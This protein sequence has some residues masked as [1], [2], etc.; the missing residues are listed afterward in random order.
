MSAYL[1]FGKFVAWSIGAF[2]VWTVLRM[3]AKD[4]SKITLSRLVLPVIIILVGSSGLF[5]DAN[6]SRIEVMV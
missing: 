1:T 2:M 4:I 6:T 3:W 5:G